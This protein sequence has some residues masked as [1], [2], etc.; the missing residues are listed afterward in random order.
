MKATIK[1]PKEGLV[2]NV[3]RKSNPFAPD[4]EPDWIP[5][6]NATGKAPD[7][8]AGREPVPPP[9]PPPRQ[10]TFDDA[11]PMNSDANTNLRNSPPA[12]PRKPLSLSSQTSLRGPIL[13]SSTMQQN[14]SA[15]IGSLSGQT[16]K[17][18]RAS[19]DLLGDVAGEQ[20]EWKPLLPQR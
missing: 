14:A 6:P 12:V 9:P 8:V 2:A 3:Q 7:A 11:E 10:R 16:G 5:N 20:I 1:P 4:S 15:Q 17:V 18:R 19:T 13:R